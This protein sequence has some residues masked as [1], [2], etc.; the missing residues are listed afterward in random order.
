MTAAW[1]AREA[2]FLLPLSAHWA[3]VRSKYSRSKHSRSTHLIG[4]SSKALAAMTSAYSIL[5]EIDR[6][7]GQFA[8]ALHNGQLRIYLTLV[9]IVALS[10][11]LFPPKD[12]PDRI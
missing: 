6:V 11:L 7:C 3:A 10:A 8:S 9:V 4:I 12:D 2:I 1:P 5:V